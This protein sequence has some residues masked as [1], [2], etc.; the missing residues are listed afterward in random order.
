[1]FVLLGLG[2]RNLQFDL[3]HFS[4]VYRQVD[5][6]ENSIDVQ[7]EGVGE[8]RRAGRKESGRGGAENRKEQNKRGGGGC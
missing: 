2:D 6:L 8:R 4:G 7:M 3:C 1:M 5:K